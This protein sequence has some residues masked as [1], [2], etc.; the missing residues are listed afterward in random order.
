[1]KNYKRDKNHFQEYFS[2]KSN[3]EL[4]FLAA[5]FR[6]AYNKKVPSIYSLSVKAAVFLDRKETYYSRSQAIDCLVEAGIKSRHAEY[7]AKDIHLDDFKL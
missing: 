2:N 7:S 5:Q 6:G 3:E 4:N 1:M